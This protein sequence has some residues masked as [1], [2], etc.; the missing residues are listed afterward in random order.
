MCNEKDFVLIVTI[1]K[2]GWGDEVI[3]A[4]RKAGAHGGTILF[5]RGTG[6]HENKSIL[7]LM[8]EPEKEIVLTVAESTI[9]D[10]IKNSIIEAVNL[11]EPGKG[12]G[13]V[14]SLDKVFGICHPLYDMLH[15]NREI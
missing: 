6:V 8:I 3:K 7:G 9:E 15:S 11:N 12:I 2:K 1:V 10:K 4:S 5:G 14:V 13:F